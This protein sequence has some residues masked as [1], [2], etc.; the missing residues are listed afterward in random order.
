MTDLPVPSHLRGLWALMP[1]RSASKVLP[2]PRPSNTQ[3]PPREGH[4]PLPGSLVRPASAAPSPRS[5]KHSGSNPW[6][7]AARS[8]TR[9]TDALYEDASNRAATRNEQIAEKLLAIEVLQNTAPTGKP[10]AKMRPKEVEELGAYF[11]EVAVARREQKERARETI[12]QSIDER[13]RST[14]KLGASEQAVVA[15]R[16]SDSGSQKLAALEAARQQADERLRRTAESPR[17]SPAEH[18]EMLTRLDGYRQQRAARLQAETAARMQQAAKATRVLDPEERAEML[19]RLMGYGARKRERVEAGQQELAA[20][21]R[22][23]ASTKF[24]AKAEA[25]K[26][27]LAREEAAALWSTRRPRKGGGLTLLASPHAP[28]V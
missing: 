25:E 11:Q 16:M 14:R 26:A 4:R 23:L 22:Q 1:P 21:S 8:S 12:C 18:K 7:K 20:Q 27:A 3:P 15:A 10:I 9:R 28:T 2:R 6:E 5:A 13:A 24:S 17:M 19:A